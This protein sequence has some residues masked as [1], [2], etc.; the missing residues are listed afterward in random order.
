MSALDDAIE[1]T[2]R[3]GIDAKAKLDAERQRN[4]ELMPE[5]AKVLDEM[6]K[7][8]GVPA[9]FRFTEGGLTVE[10]GERVPVSWNSA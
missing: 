7:H 9:W 4:R 5:T 2:R 8:F 3:R 10:W 6:R 1:R